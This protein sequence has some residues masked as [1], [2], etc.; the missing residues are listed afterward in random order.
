MERFWADVVTPYWWASVIVAGIVG[1]GIASWFFGKVKAAIE[2]DKK[3]TAEEHT[4]RKRKLARHVVYCHRDPRLA[5]M[6]AARNRHYM[7]R[8]VLYS[9]F[10]V[11]MVGALEYG[12]KGDAPLLPILKWPVMGVILLFAAAALYFAKTAI[13]CA[14]VF[15]A[16]TDDLLRAG[17]ATD[18]E[19]D[20]QIAKKLP[21][22]AP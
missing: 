8:A 1:N 9:A 22:R 6:L 13:F 20:D 4:A 15:E 3:T 2:W 16:Y 10:A 21:A 17:V 14:E 19:I 5:P 11:L 7:I 18:A 12:P